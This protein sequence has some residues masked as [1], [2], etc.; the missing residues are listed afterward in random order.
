MSQFSSTRL[1]DWSTANTSNTFLPQAVAW[2]RSHTPMGRLSDLEVFE[3]L[4]AASSG[5][6]GPFVITYNT[7][8]VP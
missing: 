8:A 6:G 5:G 7:H 2:L 1:A 3:V 4:Q